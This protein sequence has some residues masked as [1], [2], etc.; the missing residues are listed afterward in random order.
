MP[1]ISHVFF[2]AKSENK[3]KRKH[4]FLTLWLLLSRSQFKIHTENLLI[5]GLNLF[6]DET[7]N[8]WCL[9]RVDFTLTDDEEN[10][11]VLLDVAIFR[12]VAQSGVILHQ[13]VKSHYIRFLSHDYIKNSN[14]KKTNSHISTLFLCARACFTSF[15]SQ[16]RSWSCE[17]ISS[18]YV[19]T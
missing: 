13:I 18:L 3:M 9:S 10:N 14:L 7:E 11:C 6:T 16:G 19:M 15:K 4:F 2:K 1:I 5:R 17:Q 12:Q 8:C